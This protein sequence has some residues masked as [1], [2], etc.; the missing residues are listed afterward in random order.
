MWIDCDYLFQIMNSIPKTNKKFSR[1]G[2]NDKKCVMKDDES[3]LESKVYSSH[4]Q[5]EDDKCVAFNIE[6]G[7]E[8]VDSSV[9][10]NISS[11][12][13]R[14]YQ[15]SLSEEGDLKQKDKM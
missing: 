14:Q 6:E 11:F 10:N 1:D 15:N 12:R 4:K 5:N 7:N 3:S 9:E 8:R 13:E 2:Q